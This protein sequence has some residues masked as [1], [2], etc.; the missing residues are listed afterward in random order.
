MH[1]FLKKSSSEAV[2]TTAVRQPK[3]FVTWNCNGFSVRLSKNNGTDLQKFVQFVKDKS[4]DVITLQEV[5]MKSASQ[6][7]RSELASNTK[8]LREECD[9]FA[10]FKRKLPDYKIKL[11]LASTKYAGQ[12]YK[13]FHR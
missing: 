6:I 12:V 1:A 2:N 8:S 4:P 10:A 5:R 11:S 13:L 3:I 7:A 9:L